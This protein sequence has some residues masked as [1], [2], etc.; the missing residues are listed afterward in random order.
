M[1]EVPCGVEGE[2]LVEVW[3]RGKVLESA[4]LWGRARPCCLLDR[5]GAQA[6]IDYL[7]G[8]GFDDFLLFFDA[9]KS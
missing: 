6:P 1:K 9:A 8:R 5:Q 4:P 2:S 7:I 3:R